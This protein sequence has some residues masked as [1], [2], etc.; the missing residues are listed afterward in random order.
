M[1]MLAACGTQV[2]QVE[3]KSP[4]A[5]TDPVKVKPVAITKVVAKIRRGEDV[6]EYQVGALCLP[7]SKISWKSGSK[8]NLSSEELV[9]VFREELELNGWPV[10]GSTEDLFSGYDVSGAELLIAA[11]ITD[12][13]TAICFPYSGFGN[14]MSNG[15]M[16]L[17]VEWQIYNPARKT[18][19][20]TVNTAGSAIIKN[21][22][23]DAG[24]EL[25][26][27][28]FSVAVNNL[29][30][31]NSFREYVERATLS[32]E[33]I[34]KET[35]HQ[36]N[37]PDVSYSSI[38]E[39]LENAR[40]STVI[41]RTATGHGSGF[42][43]GMGDL[44][45]TNAHVVGNAQNVTI[46][47]SSKIRLQGKVETVDKGRDIALIKISGINLPP[48]RIYE[49][50]LIVAESLFAIG[51]PLDETLSNTVTQGIFSSEREYDGYYWI[52]SDVSINP[53]NSGGPLLNSSG[54]VVGISTAGFQ[55]AGSQVG[56]NLFIP[57]GDGLKY[58]GISLN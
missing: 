10:V 4:I 42:A 18:I 26:A 54:Y 58:I 29:L 46:I 5:I 27:Q 1:L 22:V 21:V 36:I 52:Q 47:T 35:I 9:D 44:I 16:R 24:Y 31:N 45:L 34:P 11:K 2:S 23:D 28:S 12:I 51:A 39:A 19:I 40:L 20:G 49:G 8:V 43:V 30:A 33:P 7:N 15:S 32:A 55:P 41:V 13:E 50:G 25:M 3:I 53:G 56:L 57:I 48:L 6:G 17:K 37:N 14:F 38:K